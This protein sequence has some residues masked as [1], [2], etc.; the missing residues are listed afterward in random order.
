MF[1]LKKIANTRIKKTILIATGAII[2]LMVLIIAFISPI[3]KYLI[4]KNGVKYT[5]RKI[6]LDWAY[7]NP[8]TGYIHFSN[9]KV[10]ELKSDSVFFSADGISI[11]I[12]MHK[13]L[14]GT[15]E[16]S[17]FTLNHPRTTIIQS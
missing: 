8:F 13:L 9:F 6:T 17:E 2:I 4:E 1:S 10:Y 12:A 7:V 11:N 3:T 5:G 14:S 16:I 15:Y